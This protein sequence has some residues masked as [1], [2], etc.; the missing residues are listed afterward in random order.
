MQWYYAQEGQQVGPVD[1]AG[2]QQLVN[3]GTITPETLVWHAGMA[4]WAA[5]STV[6]PAA[7]PAAAPGL[8]QFLAKPTEPAAPDQAAEEDEEFPATPGITTVLASRRAALAEESGKCTECGRTFPLTEMVRYENALICG[9]CKPLFFQ[10]LREGA[11][12]PTEMEYGG[13][14]I[15]FGAKWLDGLILGVIYKLLEFLLGVVVKQSELQEDLPKAFAF[16]GIVIIAQLAIDAAYKI[17]FLGKFGATP[18][19]MACRLKV[20]RPDG[21]ELGYARAF[22]RYFAEWLSILTFLFLGFGYLMAA[23]DDEKR[24]LHDRLAGTR[25]IRAE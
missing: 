11:P 17:L 7:A 18:G 19:K 4:N 3:A 16:V 6:A 8:A 1:D 21:S 2:L 20:V 10:R 24:A 23:W 9:T 5:Y 22:G 14:W 12:L 13:F 25:V 15:R